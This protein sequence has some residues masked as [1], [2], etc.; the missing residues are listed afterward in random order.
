MIGQAA[1]AQALFAH[2][3]PFPLFAVLLRVGAPGSGSSRAVASI[4][5]SARAFSLF[6]PL[7]FNPSKLEKSSSTHLPP[8]LAGAPQPARPPSIFDLL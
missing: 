6:N 2:S 3:S 7:R 1:R 5:A 4:T 8:Q